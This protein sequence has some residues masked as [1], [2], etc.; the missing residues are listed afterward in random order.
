MDK[1]PAKRMGRPPAPPG[2]GQTEMIRAR[3][4]PAQREKFDALGGPDWLRRQIERATLPR[5]ADTPGAAGPK[6]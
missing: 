4:T 5:P 1:A 3:C 2:V 6:E